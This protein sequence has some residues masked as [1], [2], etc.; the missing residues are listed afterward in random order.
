MEPPKWLH[1]L[2]AEF[3]PVIEIELPIFK[4]LSIWQIRKAAPR[5]IDGN[6]L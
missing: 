6:D 5:R 4:Q 1:G 2:K 3:H